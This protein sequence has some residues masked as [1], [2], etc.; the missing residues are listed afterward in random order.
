MKLRDALLRHLPPSA[1]SLSSSLASG[2]KTDSQL[3]NGISSTV[4]CSALSSNVKA[5]VGSSSQL[6]SAA[7]LINGQDGSRQVG[8]DFPIR[9]SLKNSPKSEGR[10][11]PSSVSSSPAKRV[12]FDLND[13]LHE[14]VGGNVDASGVETRATIA[15][16]IAMLS[17]EAAALNQ[18]VDGTGDLPPPRVETSSADAC[19]KQLRSKKAN[20]KRGVSKRELNALNSSNKLFINRYDIQTSLVTDDDQPTQQESDKS[21]PRRSG[22]LKRERESTASFEI[23]AIVNKSSDDNGAVEDGASLS[24]WVT[25]NGNATLYSFEEKCKAEVIIVNNSEASSTLRANANG[26]SL[27]RSAGGSSLPIPHVVLKP[28]PKEI[29]GSSSSLIGCSSSSYAANGTLAASPIQRSSN[30]GGDTKQPSPLKASPGGDHRGYCTCSPSSYD[31]KSWSCVDG[32]PASASLMGGRRL[33]FDDRY[34]NGYETTSTVKLRPYVTL[35]PTVVVLEPEEAV[36]PEAAEK[37]SDI[38]LETSRRISDGSSRSGS[39]AGLRRSLRSTSHLNLSSA[40]LDTSSCSSNDAS[41]TS[42]A[43]SFSDNG[44]AVN[45]MLADAKI[46]K[47]TRVE[48]NKLPVQTITTATTECSMVPLALK[49]LVQRVTAKD[50]IAQLFNGRMTLRTKCLECERS[51][52][53]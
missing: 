47:L 41:L 39:V 30:S 33:S 19:A 10:S 29:S 1:S 9:S 50:P 42:L 27:L 49:Q 4:G 5:S 23:S 40:S 21:Q 37:V 25:C 12:R 26:S 35:S 53:G 31:W 7:D 16:T 17:D 18:R 48:L 22:R 24:E 51:V 45:V 11:S 34:G 32:M 38:Q 15:R 36:T 43:E 44:N 20:T 3:T 52:S 2:S 14:Y 46:S 13:L 6:S 8:V 28:L